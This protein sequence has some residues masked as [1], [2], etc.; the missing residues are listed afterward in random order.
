MQAQHGL[1]ILAVARW[2]AQATPGLG[3]MHLAELWRADGDGVLDLQQL[4]AQEAVAAARCARIS[5]VTDAPAHHAVR[6]QA[7][8]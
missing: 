4:R 8:L 6:L 1:Q 7:P 3:R 5:D 2:G